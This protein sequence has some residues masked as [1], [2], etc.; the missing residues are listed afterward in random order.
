MLS[1][2][3]L[4]LSVCLSFCVPICLLVCIVSQCCWSSFISF[5]V[6]YVCLSLYLSA[7]LSLCLSICLWVKGAGSWPTSP[8]V[9]YICKVCSC[10]NGIFLQGQRSGGGQIINKPWCQFQQR[11]I[12]FYCT[13]LRRRTNG[14][15]VIAYQ[16]ESPLSPN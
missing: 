3:F 5:S 6:Y 13:L 8:R 16:I 11:N 1:Q 10:G 15:V 14:Y 7:R 4:C 2:W 12:L 9:A